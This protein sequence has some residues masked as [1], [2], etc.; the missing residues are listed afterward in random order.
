MKYIPIT[1]NNLLHN[2][3]RD[4]EKK[5]TTHTRYG[6][7]DIPEYRYHPVNIGEPIIF[8]GRFQEC[9]WGIL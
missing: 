8:W 5:K 3:R 9:G 7:N 6:I 2:S 1:N 4:S